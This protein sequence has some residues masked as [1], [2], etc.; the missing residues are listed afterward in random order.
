[1]LNDLQDLEL[2]CTCIF[3]LYPRLKVR[4]EDQDDDDDFSE[5]DSESRVFLKFIDSLHF[6]GI[7]K[8][9]KQVGE[10]PKQIA[11]SNSAALRPR[12]VLSS[13]ENDE[14]IGSIND[15]VNKESRAHRQRDVRVKVGN[16]EAK[17]SSNQVNKIGIPN[18]FNK[19]GDE[20]LKCKD[21]PRAKCTLSNF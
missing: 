14:L 7:L 10:R 16:H 5:S 1:M 19:E 4:T 12:A 6:E 15:L 2:V 9:S 20:A 13:P 11:R 21:P 18:K 8:N 17:V 3:L